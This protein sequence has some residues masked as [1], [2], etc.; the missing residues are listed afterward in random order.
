[1]ATGARLDTVTAGGQPDWSYY[2]QALECQRDANRVVAL[3]GGKIAAYPEHGGRW[4]FGEPVNLDSIGTL[5]LE[6]LMY[7]K[8]FID[9]LRRRFCRGRVYKVDTA[10]NNAYYPEWLG[11]AKA[12]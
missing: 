7:I 3:L 6:R 2:L 4:G 1:M 10:T 9:K 12:R 11:A 5:N 8:S